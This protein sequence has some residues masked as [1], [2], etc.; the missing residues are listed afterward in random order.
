MCLWQVKLSQAKTIITR[1]KKHRRKKRR[2]RK[3]PGECLKKKKKSRSSVKNAAKRFV[4]SDKKLQLRKPRWPRRR[5]KEKRKRFCV[6]AE[7]L[8]L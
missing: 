3:T 6:N 1:K 5:Q 4:S 2:Q 7:R 8:V